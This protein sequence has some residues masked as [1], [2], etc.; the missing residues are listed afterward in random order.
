[1]AIMEIKKILTEGG[2]K[3]EIMDN[4]YYYCYVELGLEIDEM[5]VREIVKKLPLKDKSAFPL[6]M[7][8]MANSTGAAYAQQKRNSGEYL[9]VCFVNFTRH[10]VLSIIKKSFI[11]GVGDAQEGTTDR[12]ISEERKKRESDPKETVSV[13]PALTPKNRKN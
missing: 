1:M 5:E 9:S 6:F 11:S 10:A 8:L 4:I 2:P 13:P 3:N 12:R 7:W